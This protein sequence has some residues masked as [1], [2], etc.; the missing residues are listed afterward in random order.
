MQGRN[1]SRSGSMVLGDAQVQ[2]RS[3]VCPI[4]CFT[5]QI[6]SS[7]PYSTLN[8]RPTPYVEKAEIRPKRDGGSRACSAGS[9]S[10]VP[11]CWII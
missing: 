2:S 6:L 11:T 10:C 9:S 1:G 3:F 8:T 4:L 7:L 5:M